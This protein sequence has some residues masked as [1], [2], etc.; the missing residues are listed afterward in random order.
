M[1]EAEEVPEEVW[2][3]VPEAE[4]EL[5][6]VAE[7]DRVPL[8]ESVEVPDRVPESVP[9]EDRLLVEVAE[10]LLV[11]RV[12]TVVD[13]VDVIVLDCVLEALAVLELVVVRE[14][15]D[16]PVEVL[17]LVEVFESTAELVEVR[18]TVDD[19]DE[20]AL[21]VEVKLAR[22][23]GEDGFEGR[24]VGVDLPLRVAVRVELPD[25]VGRTPAPLNSLCH[26]TKDGCSKR[27]LILAFL[28]D[29][30]GGSLPLATTVASPTNKNVSNLIL[31][32]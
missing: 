12:L 14:E 23:D 22:E 20:V 3:R 4:R 8:E 29:V 18:D 11:G 19:L 15:L 5:V 17:L 7:D 1:T 26:G 25:L 13:L 28:R 9:L 21:L 10:E 32:I 31:C 30:G 2:D 6:E 16:E 27:K 24:A